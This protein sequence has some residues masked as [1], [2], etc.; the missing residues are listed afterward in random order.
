MAACSCAT[1]RHTDCA[2]PCACRWSPERLLV[3]LGDLDQ[4][5]AGV[6]E[7]CYGDGPHVGGRL[8]ELH[9]C[10]AQPGIFGLDVTHAERGGGDAVLLERGFVFPGGRVRIG[11]EQQLDAVGVVG[12][13]QGQPAVAAHGDIV[14]GLETEY[15]MVESQGFGLVVDEDA[16]DYDLHEHALCLEALSISKDNRG[17]LAKSLWVFTCE[18][19]DAIRQH[20]PSRSKFQ[21]GWWYWGR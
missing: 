3:F 10:R 7:H 15:V 12:R 5:A 14:L 13:G 11:F 6:I 18:Y 16:G 19:H 8:G 20:F 1:R 21:M 4:V 2:R 9:A 17:L